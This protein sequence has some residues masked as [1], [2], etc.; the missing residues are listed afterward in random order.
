MPVVSALGRQR[1][2][3]KASPGYIARPSVVQ[4]AK[5]GRSLEFKNLRPARC[6]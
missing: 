6:Q 4:E 3:F 2:E 1:Q 5:T